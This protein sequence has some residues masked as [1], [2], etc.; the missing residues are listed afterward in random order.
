[1]TCTTHIEGPVAGDDELGVLVVHHA[2]LLPAL[3]RGGIY[4]DT[5]RYWHVTYDDIG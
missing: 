2:V 1:M 5:Y 4:V 3:D